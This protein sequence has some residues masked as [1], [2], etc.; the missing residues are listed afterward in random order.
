MTSSEKKTTTKYLNAHPYGE[1]QGQQCEQDGEKHQDPT[2]QANV[3]VCILQGC[4][5]K[6]ICIRINF[7]YMSIQQQQQKMITHKC[8]LS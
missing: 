5:A 1:R 8:T 4:K 2:A 6:Q 7:H 3:T